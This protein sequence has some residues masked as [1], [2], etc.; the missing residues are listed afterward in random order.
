VF[1]Y[2][3]KLE[4]LRSNS[5]PYRRKLQWYNITVCICRSKTVTEVGATAV[6]SVT[7]ANLQRLNWIY[8]TA[9]TVKLKVKVK[10]KVKR[11]LYRPGQVHRILER[12]CSQISWQSTMKVLR[13]SDLRTGCLYPPPQK[14]FLVLIYVLGWAD[15]RAIVG[16]D[17]LS[18]KYSNDTIG[19]RTR[20]LPVLAP[21]LDEIPHQVLHWRYCSHYDFSHS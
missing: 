19:N 8:V 9:D 18:I 16:P 4:Y 6:S 12:P 13:L 17:G 3:R 21:C 14:I 10:V 11:F 15:P 20:D 5:S 2:P 7:S 1:K